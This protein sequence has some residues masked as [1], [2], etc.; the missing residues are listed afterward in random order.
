MKKLV[1]RVGLSLALLGISACAIVEP[2]AFEK[3]YPDAQDL[4]QIDLQA[5]VDTAP[6]PGS[7]NVEVYI[8]G[9]N[10]CPKNARCIIPDGIT[11]AKVKD[12]QLPEEHLH[13][14]VNQPQQFQRNRRY[15][16]SIAVDSAGW[17]DSITGNP[18]RKM[19]LIGYSQAK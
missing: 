18:V 11:V 13:I 5:L 17:D 7:Y 19:R 10:V 6:I 9:I 8:V 12:P 3:T 1:Q 16:L 2:E 4:Q 14:D 15:V